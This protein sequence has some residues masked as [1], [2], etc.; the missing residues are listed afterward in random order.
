MLQ[1]IGILAFIFA[2]LF[3]VM[4][5]EFGHYLTAKRFGMKVTEFFLGFGKKIWSFTR[6]ETEF[7]IKAIPAGGYCRVV[8]MSSR[9]ELA[10][11]EEGRAFY[12]ATVPQRLITM[13]AGSTAHFLFGFILL[14]TLAF[15]IGT[16]ASSPVIDKVIPCFA[17]A[18]S[19]CDSATNPTP[20]Q[21][22]GLKHGDRFMAINGKKVTNWDKDILAVQQSPGKPV[23]ISI[24]RNGE[25]LDLAITPSPE[26]VSG[27]IVGKLG[28]QVAIESA[29]K[30]NGLHDSLAFASTNF[31][32]IFSSSIHS[33]ISLPAKIP[34]LIKQ[35]F[36]GAPRDPQGLVGVVGVAQ[37][38]A[39]TASDSRL[40]WNERIG[41]F[42]LI[43]ASLNIF[44]GIFNLLPLLPLD[45]G[46]MAVA[47]ADGIRRVWARL[48]RRPEPRPIALESLMPL[49]VVVF[50]LFVALTLLLLAADIFNP[51]HFNL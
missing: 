12:R 10:P 8:G 21:L 17:A 26:K 4:L 20:A 28:I 7:G 31:G 30:R 48:R 25:Q 9:E 32:E 33:L 39:Q 24:L 42:I 19:T 3:S 22:L 14:F 50:V 29:L 18:N 35:T 13:G 51:V 16:V 43:V 5:H 47:I 40:G 11:D 45:G 27:K 46:H 36:G 6:G 44:V 15:G 2:L 1:L 23:A 49:T 37:A 38:T 34:A 41:T